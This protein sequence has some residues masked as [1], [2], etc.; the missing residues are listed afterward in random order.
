MLFGVHLPQVGP[1]GRRENVLAFARRAEAL[2]FHSLFVSDHIVIPRQIAG[3][4]AGGGR[5][6]VPPDMPFLEGISLLHFVAAATERILLGTSVIV[7]PMRNPVVTAK[8]L[9]T[10]DVL[11]GGRL[12]FGVGAGWMAE[13]FA[14]LGV[15]FRGHGPRTDEYLEV[16][17]RL[18]TEEE[19]SFRGRYFRL[20]GVGFAP[21]PLQQP[22]P[23]IWVGG[24]AE[25]AL[26]RAGTYGDAWHATGTVDADLLARSFARVQEYARQAGRDPQRLLFS[27]RADRFLRGEPEQ[28]VAVLQSLRRIGVQ[29]VLTAFPAPS[30]EES[31][32]LM[33]GFARQVVPALA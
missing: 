26:R 19:P 24:M 9:A 20:E 25:G 17:R 15:P 33:E 6:P 3:Q 21:K 10:L 16:V 23:P 1:L 4:Y 27:V 8:E 14:A 5:F 2:G 12:I 30:L 22:H 28:V 29:H 13:E 32:A 11:S 31:L 18:W 7:L